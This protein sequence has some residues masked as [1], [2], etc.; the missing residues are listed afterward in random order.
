MEMNGI[1]IL[2]AII[3]SVILI[4]VI[5]YL[6]RDRL[7][8]MNFEFLK[9]LIKFGSKSTP[10]GS[11]NVVAVNQ[12]EDV[13]FEKQYMSHAVLHILQSELKKTQGHHA[14]LET[15]TENYHAASTLYGQIHGDIIG[16]CFFESP[17]YGEHRDLAEAILSGSRFARISTRNMCNEETQR[18]VADRFQSYRA[19][20]RL[21]VLSEETEVSKI[22][23][24][25]C[26]CDD[27]SHL[28]FM[29]L[30]NYVDAKPKN[31]GLVYCGDLAEQM[32]KY[33]KSFVDRYE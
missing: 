18:K 4:G 8:E 5:T 29:A 7:S 13:P 25:F 23:G 31:L 3:G 32:Y 14:V 26:K 10:K 2:V 20:A 6:L 9:G 11:S 1:Y 19:R 27:G 17:D 24:I 12:E 28:A 30:N 21:I 22:G 15:T 16:T 33:Y